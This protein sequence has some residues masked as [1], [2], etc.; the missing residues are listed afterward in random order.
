MTRAKGRAVVPGLRSDGA[1]NE[2]LSDE[3]R[4]RSEGGM[5]RRAGPPE[6]SWKTEHEI[7][8]AGASSGRTWLSS[9]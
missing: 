1:R 9:G 5:G 6:A 2:R 7:R 4:R 8:E 3:G